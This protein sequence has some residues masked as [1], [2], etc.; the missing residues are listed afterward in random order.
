MCLQGSGQSSS[1]TSVVVVVKVPAA[2][3]MLRVPSYP[4]VA[5]CEEV[6]GP[7]YK[8]VWWWQ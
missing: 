4:S 6:E 2:H 7:L 5:L 3:L 8:V 1:Y